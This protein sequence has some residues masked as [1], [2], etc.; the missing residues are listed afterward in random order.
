[1]GPNSKIRVQT[2]GP[3]YFFGPELLNSGP[4][5]G[6]FKLW[7][8]MSVTL[9]PNVFWTRMNDI[10]VRTGFAESGFTENGM[11]ARNVVL[12]HGR[13]LAF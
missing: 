7:T 2:F 9:D 5:Y 4:K 8:R 12:D 13:D 3:N 11:L 6:G 10:W 1:M